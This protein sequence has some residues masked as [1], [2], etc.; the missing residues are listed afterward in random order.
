MAG[1]RD[2]RD[3]ERVHVPA[4]ITSEGTDPDRSCAAQQVYQGAS[5]PA[6]PRTRAEITRFFDGLDLVVPGVTDIALWP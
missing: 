5:A 2:S 1:F 4:G 3:L 6:V